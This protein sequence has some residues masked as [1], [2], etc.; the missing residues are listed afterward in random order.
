[1][2]KRTQ[3]LNYVATYPEAVIHVYAS[4]IQPPVGING[5]IKGNRILLPHCHFYLT[6]TSTSLPLLAL[7]V[8][9]PTM[10]PSLYN[11][12]SA[13]EAELGAL[14]HNSKEACPLCT[15][16]TKMGHLQKATTITTTN[17][18]AAGNINPIVKQR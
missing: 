5:L 14:F 12:V 10:V 3:L 7:K 17:T 1:M 13:A 11:V 16:L 18:C 9:H 8:Q 6:A 2:K 15:A 4:F